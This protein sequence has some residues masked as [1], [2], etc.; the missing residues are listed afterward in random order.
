MYINFGEH[1][2][3]RG[4]CWELSVTIGQFILVRTVF[5]LPKK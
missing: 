2:K 4:N 3:S 1:L 5:L